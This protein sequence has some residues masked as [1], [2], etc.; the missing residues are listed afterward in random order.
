MKEMN[1]QNQSNSSSWFN[2]ALGWLRKNFFP[3]YPKEYAKVL[4]FT[5]IFCGIVFIYT[6]CRQAKDFFI[7]GVGGAN[8]IPP[9]KVLVIVA[10][11]LL[12][13]LHSKITRKYNHYKAFL[14]SFIPF[15]VFF[16]LFA[17]FFKHVDMVHMSPETIQRLSNQVP[18]LRYFFI[19]IGNWV[20]CL[21]YIFSEMFGSFM[22]GATFWQ[23]ASFYSTHDEAKRFYPFYALFAQVGGFMGGKVMQLIGDFVSRTNNVNYGVLLITLTI[24][25]TAVIIIGAV[26]YF[27]KVTILNPIYAVDLQQHQH[28][29]KNRP[30]LHW[31]E[32]LK[33]LR[34]HPTL[35]L[36]CLLTIWY[37]ICT[38]SME[39]FWKGKVRE[40]YGNGGALMSFFGIYYQCMSIAAFAVSI[41]AAPLVRRLP[42]L[43][44]ALITPLIAIIAPVFLF[45]INSSTFKSLFSNFLPVNPLY[46]CVMVGAVALIF[47]KAAKY[48]LFDSTK[49]IFIR[50]Q[51]E[52]DIIQVKSLETFV[53]RLGKGGSAVLQTCILSI[54]GMTM[55]GMSPVLWV[56]VSIMG[57]VWVYSILAIN[58][59]MVVIESKNNTPS[60]TPNSNSTSAK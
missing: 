39:T 13:I 54:P 32:S 27:F 20:Y 57:V 4:P 34:N 51:K 16:I 37:G 5:I 60:N 31:K 55:E 52:D 36:A 1:N 12:G 2:N 30:K 43:V 49:E 59:E 10:A 19:I 35:I 14:I 21:N 42:W 11:G 38:T 26:T 8:V 50:A 9:A 17:I 40:Y 6:V 33:N 18:V 48:V 53:G 58:K 24:L 46:L 22:L 15:V 47:F 56:T 41:L 45:G 23:L 28:S 3:I 7:M 29:K 44:P 25:I